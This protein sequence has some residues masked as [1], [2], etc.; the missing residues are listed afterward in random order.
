MATELAPTIHKGLDVLEDQWKA[1]R[2]G[3]SKNG[4]TGSKPCNLYDDDKKCSA[5]DDRVGIKLWKLWQTA[6]YQNSC[7]KIRKEPT[8]GPRG[9]FPVS[10]F[11]EAL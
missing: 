6:E 7:E 4:L 9:L 11:N 5:H 1:G 2:T 8:P 3:W 10:L